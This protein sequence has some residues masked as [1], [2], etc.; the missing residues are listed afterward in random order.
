MAV[1]K[2]IVISWKIVDIIEALNVNLKKIIFCKQ[3]SQ[4]TE[5][6]FLIL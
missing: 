3:E 1:K 2:L 4:K 6:D 5:T